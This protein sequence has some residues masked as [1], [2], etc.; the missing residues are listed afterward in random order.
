MKGAPHADDG[1]DT[2]TAK[3]VVLVLCGF[4]LTTALVV[5]M[6]S[7]STQA[8][9]YA[10]VAGWGWLALDGDTLKVLKTPNGANPLV[11]GMTPLLGIDVWEHAY[12]LD[13]ENRRPE[14]VAAFLNHLV[15]WDEVGAELHKA[16]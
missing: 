2:G 9:A 14:Y 7:P 12:Y 15:N 16:L 4:Q 8:G 10:L 3:V 6:I 13:Y 11:E 5:L 1:I